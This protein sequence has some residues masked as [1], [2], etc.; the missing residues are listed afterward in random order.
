MSTDRLRIGISACLVGHE[1]RYN[2]GHL[3]DGF[4]NGALAP[5]VD[6]VT[7]CPEVEV[8]MGVPREEVR[9]VANP[10]A[11]RMVGSRSKTDHTD[12]MLRWSE[13]RAQA[14]AGENLDGFLL[15]ANSPSCGL[16]RVRLY[17]SAGGTPSR[18]GVGLFA[19]ALTGAAPDLPVE[20]NGRLRDPRLRENF[21]EHIFV[22]R[23]WRELMAT[24]PTPRG[25]VGF[26][27]T[28][29]FT[30]LAHNPKLYREMGR[31]VAD[32][33]RQP[34]GLLSQHY[35][36]LM[37]TALK[38][39]ATPRKHTNVLHHV[40]GFLKGYLDEDDKRELLGTIE[41]YR[42]ELVPL[43][44]PITLLSHHLR[45]HGAD[46][47]VRQQTYLNPYPGELMLRNHV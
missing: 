26:H 1:V 35:V 40:M 9:L 45:H 21:V 38:S 8:G 7:V 27:S 37:T 24:N 25:L 43:I 29:K 33:G 14:L 2:G 20:E 3:S 32:A 34:W 4:I 30:F 6:W 23:R 18:S 46:D 19:R 17:P 11:P 10:A 16:L 5:Y 15:T 31:I 36:E 39:M 47:W 44:V 12:A 41:S 13:E 28:H 22:R 42:H